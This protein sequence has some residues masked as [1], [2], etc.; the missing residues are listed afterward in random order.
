ML[1]FLL[2]CINL[3]TVSTNLNSINRLRRQSPFFDGIQPPSNKYEPRLAISTD[4]HRKT[5]A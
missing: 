5:E 2:L 1:K 4:A 3:C